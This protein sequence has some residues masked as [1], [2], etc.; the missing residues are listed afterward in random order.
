MGDKKVLK[1][2][3]VAVLNYEYKTKSYGL[4]LNEYTPDIVKAEVD[5]ISRH[6]PELD[7][8]K[9]YVYF[10]KHNRSVIKEVENIQEGIEEASNY[11]GDA[12][13]ISEGKVYLVVQKS[14]N[15]EIET[16]VD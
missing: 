14:A 9:T 2:S 1:D 10:K 3:L 7:K 8:K 16:V 4:E 12:Y 13:I 5:R 11:I 6:R 15:V